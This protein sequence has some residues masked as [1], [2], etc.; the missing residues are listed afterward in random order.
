MKLILFV[1]LLLSQSLTAKPCPKKPCPKPKPCP[2][3]PVCP[4]PPPPTPGPAPTCSPSQAVWSSADNWAFKAFGNI[5]LYNNMWSGVLGSTMWAKDATC[6]GTAATYADNGGDTKTFIEAFRGY[7]YNLPSSATSGLP[8]MMS[9]L[10]SVKV[11]WNM[12]TPKAGRYMALWD[13]YFNKTATIENRQGDANL[14]LF[15]YVYDRTG[16]IGSDAD[17]VGGQDVTIGGVQWRYRYVLNDPRVNNGPVLVMYAYPRM[18]NSQMGL[19]SASIDV[20]AIF[21]WAVAQKI[22]DASFYLKEVAAG[23][24]LIESG[25]TFDGGKFQTND[26]G[27]DLP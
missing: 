3:C 9:A 22:F 27:I 13:I 15:Q 14:M 26:F 1:A 12:T 18:A 24:E 7:Q 6:W 23:W 21:D 11:R 19:Q 16:W 10:P 20:K 4:E 2:V 25:P 8:A 17:V 5:A